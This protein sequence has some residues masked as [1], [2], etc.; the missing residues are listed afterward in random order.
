ML[1]PAPGLH[2][3]L[4]EAFEGVRDNETVEEVLI[5]F[6]LGGRLGFQLLHD[7]RDGA[8]NDGQN[9]LAQLV[10]SAM[11][12]F[13]KGVAPVRT[14]S[15]RYAA[16]AP[17]MMAARSR[18]SRFFVMAVKCAARGVPLPVPCHWAT[19]AWLFR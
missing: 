2:A 11:F 10:L 9:R 8:P 15:S 7:L 19:Y 17:S 3:S 1:S 4:G 18:S 5:G 6:H 13:L 14:R 12:S 16:V